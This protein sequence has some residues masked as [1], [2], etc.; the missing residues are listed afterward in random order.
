MTLTAGPPGMEKR[1]SFF[2]V[3]DI[4]FFAPGILLFAAIWYHFFPEIAVAN[5][6]IGEIKDNAPLAIAV[7]TVSVALIYLFALS[8]TRCNASYGSSCFDVSA[9][10]RHQHH[11]HRQRTSPGSSPWTASLARNWR[12]TSAYMR[13]TCWNLA[14]AVIPS[15]FP[16]FSYLKGV[17]PGLVVSFALVLLGGV[18]FDRSIDRA[19][20]PRS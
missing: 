17:L 1:L 7:M 3:L 19:A 20:N 4:G 13:A 6:S 11:R 9:R 2:R 10:H 16:V 18:R 14:I 15:S 12:S 8:A 5:I